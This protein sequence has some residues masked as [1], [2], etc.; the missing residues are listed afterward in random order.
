MRMLDCALEY[1]CARTQFWNPNLTPADI[2]RAHVSGIICNLFFGD[3][4]DTPEEAVRLC[5]LGLDAILTNWANTVLPVVR[6]IP[7][8]M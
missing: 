1:G 7:V 5:Q 6:Q 8:N 2:E 3:R 4:P